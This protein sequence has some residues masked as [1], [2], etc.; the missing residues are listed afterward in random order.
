[1]KKTIRLTESQL[2]RVIRNAVKYAINEQTAP[3]T[4]K[5][6]VVAV[7]DATGNGKQVYIYVADRSDMN[8][9]AKFGYNRSN[10]GVF[11]INNAFKPLN[12]GLTP[13][14]M[15]TAIQVIQAN[16][17]LDQNSKTGAVADGFVPAF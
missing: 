11:T 8:R 4:Q 9:Q 10:D 2:N 17:H 7:K 5:L 3:L 14:E 16:K 6:G 12:Q 13:E 1:M 15:T